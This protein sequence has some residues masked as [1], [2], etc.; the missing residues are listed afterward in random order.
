MEQVLETPNYARIVSDKTGI[1]EA[2]VKAA[3]R[4]L[5]EGN[6][7]PFIARYRKEM[8]R[9]LDENELRSIAREY[10]QAKNLEARRQDVLRLLAEQGALATEPQASQ[11]RQ[12]IQVA[13]T[14]TEIDDIYRP[15][16]P[17]RRTR[18]SI[19][20]ERGLGPLAEWLQTVERATPLARVM[21]EAEKYVNVE[22]GVESAGTALQGALDI[23]A[24]AIS[25]DA[26]NRRFIRTMTMRHGKMVSSAVDESAETVYEQYYRYEESLLSVPPHR[27]LAMDRG[28][29]EGALHISIAAPEVDIVARLYRRYAGSDKPDTDTVAGLQARAALDAYKRLIQP[30]VEREV[31]AELQARAEEHAIGIFGANLRSLLLQPPLRGKRVLGVDPAYRTGCKLAA[32][33]DTGKLLEVSVIYPTPPQNRVAEAEEVLLSF[34]ERHHI[35]VIAIGNGTASRETEAF[36]ADCIR[37]WHAQ[38]GRWRIAYVMVSEAGAS[39][40]SASELAGE[41]FPNL[42]VAERSAISIARRLQDPLAELVKIDPKSIGVGQYQH[43]V[44]QARLGEQLGAVVETAVNEVGVDVNTASASLL[45]YVAGLNRTTARNIVQ[46]REANGRIR[47]RKQLA[48]VPRLGPKTLEQCVGFLRVMDGDEVLDATP[49]H[50]ESYGVVE[51][52]LARLEANPTDLRETSKRRALIAAARRLPLAELAQELD[53]GVPTLRDILDALERPGR[54]PREDVPPPILRTDVM[55]MEDLSVGMELNGTVRNV[56]D[57][58]AFVDIGLK[59]D[60][61]VHISELADTFVKHPLDVVTV[62]DVVRVRVVHIDAERGRIGLSMKGLQSKQ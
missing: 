21:Q 4:L 42:D 53:T 37:T 60:G 5:D 56:V 41:E 15:F 62:G 33:D 18:A 16:R 10:E 45:S 34:V 25:D 57:F 13:Q 9:E 54:D 51:R 30:A 12:A 17:K 19:A 3:L 32:V 55:R 59:N 36:V 26:N 6:T 39:V 7:I 27:V 46:F 47:T 61:L 58:G 2:R 22:A 35:D 24:E 11:L 38:S 40:Y 44:S 20:R 31:R 49:I 29:R 43:D 50:P 1:A 23:L 52:L 14:L 8:T 28:E 48:K